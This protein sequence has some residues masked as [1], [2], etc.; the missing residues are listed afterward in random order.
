[1]YVSI[2]KIS[3][4]M[5]TFYFAGFML[6]SRTDVLLSAQDQI[7]IGA[8]FGLQ[9]YPSELDPD[10]GIKHY[11]VLYPIVELSAPL[12]NRVMI[13]SIISRTV[14]KGSLLGLADRTQR[15]ELYTAAIGVDYNFGST[16]REFRTG[17]QILTGFSTYGTDYCADCSTY[18][19][20]G[21]KLYALGT[22]PLSRDFLW[23]IRSGI[24][25]LTIRAQPHVDN[26]HLDSFNIEMLIYFLL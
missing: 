25:R 10:E 12:V 18:T 13:G 16:Q 20:W 5:V 22:Q 9:S 23:G 24:Q 7:K 6:Q 4:T 14:F 19:G 15:M 8:G 17:I 3:L 21:M 1:M 26:L 11:P 2:K